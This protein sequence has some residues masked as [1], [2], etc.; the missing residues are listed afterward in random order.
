MCDSRK[1]EA[2]CLEPTWLW[3]LLKGPSKLSTVIGTKT[4]TASL[5]CRMAL[6]VFEDGNGT[7]ALNQHGTPGTPAQAAER[8]L[9]RLE[10]TWL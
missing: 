4:G 1:S 2:R 5:I 3:L 8:T 10:P 7:V 6:F 9:C